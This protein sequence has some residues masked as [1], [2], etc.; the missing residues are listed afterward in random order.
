[1]NKTVDT[2]IIDVGK[3]MKTEKNGLSSL[4]ICRGFMMGINHMHKKAGLVC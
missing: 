2:L 3:K 1:M 4:P